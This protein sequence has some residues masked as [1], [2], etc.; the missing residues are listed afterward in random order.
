MSE[1]DETVSPEA[2]QAPA[3]RRAQMA[4][5][6]MGPARPFTEHVAALAGQTGMLRIVGARGDGRIRFPRLA[7]QANWAQEAKFDPVT[8][9]AHVECEPGFAPG[10]S[11]KPW[12]VEEIQSDV[13]GSDQTDAV[14]SAAQSVEAASAPMRA[15]LKTDEPGWGLHIT[16]SSHL[17]E[18]DVSVGDPLVS[19]AALNQEEPLLAYAPHPVTASAPDQ[20]EEKRQPRRFVFGARKKADEGAKASAAALGSL[21][22]A[23]RLDPI[24]V[25]DRSA[26]D[27]DQGDCESADLD[28][29][30]YD[31]ALDR[32][33]Q[34]M[35]QEPGKDEADRDAEAEAGTEMSPAWAASGTNTDRASELPGL[36]AQLVAPLKAMSGR[37]RVMTYGGMAGAFAVTVAGLA[38]VSPKDNAPA[39]DEPAQEASLA[40]VQADDQAADQADDQA[41]QLETASTPGQFAMP[42]E[43][44]AVQGVD[45]VLEGGRLL[46]FTRLEEAASG[47][48]QIGTLV[49][50]R[51]LA[52]S[53][54][55]AEQL[56]GFGW[57]AQADASCAL[58]RVS[59]LADPNAA[60]ERGLLSLTS[61]STPRP[62]VCPPQAATL[63]EVVPLTAGS[64]IAQIDAQTTLDVAAL[65]E[66]AVLETTDLGGQEIAYLP[67]DAVSAFFSSNQRVCVVDP[68]APQACRLT[69]D[70]DS[71]R[72]RYLVSSPLEQGAR[73]EV[74]GQ[75]AVKGD[76]VCHNTVG[77][78]A[79]VLGGDLAPEQ[80]AAIERLALE[81]NAQIEG[82]EVCFR[83]RANGQGG[84]FV[85]DAFVA[86]RMDAEYS[87]PRPFVFQTSA[88]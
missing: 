62:V 71:K 74:S 19:E 5:V 21:E 34:M 44:P 28:Q 53:D 41:D 68:A 61:I 45:P 15:A 13:D 63:G 32:D 57:F 46:A 33:D 17:S 35:A 50:F 60:D 49:D 48:A 65:R 82:G 2:E 9:I 78:S 79:L 11:Q 52:D 67:E 3:K 75:Y 81:R 42:E 87:D 58:R 26:S 38:M 72:G 14:Q 39:L 84:A 47:N 69:T 56:E 29:E 66:N 85:A 20:A 59:F 51:F 4:R 25:L 16:R 8:G 54:A 24:A 77:I 43:D 64:L 30:G 55:M 23:G 22:G 36:V 40:A 86:G 37:E 6:E 12:E 73:L 1:R 70:Y 27:L 7:E 88:L 83:L 76:A 31:D 80:A 18:S 10:R